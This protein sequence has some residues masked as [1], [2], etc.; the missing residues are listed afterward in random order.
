MTGKR[1]V[2]AVLAAIVLAGFYIHGSFDRV[3][4]GIGL[5]FHECARNGLGV[6]FC[7][8]ELDEYRARISRVKVES[9]AAAH[10]VETEGRERQERT[11]AQQQVEEAQA[12]T[13][14]K[15]DAKRIGRESAERMRETEESFKAAQGE[16]N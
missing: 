10:K 8:S 13:Q 3:L 15:E 11:N 16:G 14:A 4:S 7:G 1:R 6:T 2:L 9:Q 5:N 12:K